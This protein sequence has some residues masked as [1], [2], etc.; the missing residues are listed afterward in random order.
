[1]TRIVIAVFDGMTQ[2]DFTGPHQMLTRVAD[3]EVTVASMGGFPVRSDGLTFADLA[4]LDAIADCDVLLVPGGVGCVAAIE[5]ERFLSAVRRLGGSAAYLTSVCTGSLILAA[6]GLIEGRRAACHWAWRGTLREFGVT[7]AKDRVVR[8]GS[9]ITGGGVTAGIDFALELIAE[10]RGSAVAQAVQLRLEYAPAP[11]F[12]SGTPET[13]PPHV[14][15]AVR[16][17]WGSSL[18]VA[19]RRL[20]K[21]ALRLHAGAHPEPRP[22]VS[23]PES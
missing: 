3:F 1:M 2:L 14:V 16:A 17:F 20:A 21:A 4:D 18:D 12:D 5:D 7:P 23:R 15:E 19:H 8:D 13:A 22:A 6:T 11:P 9:V 10:L